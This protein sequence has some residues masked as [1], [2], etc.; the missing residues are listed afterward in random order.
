MLAVERGIIPRIFCKVGSRHYG[1]G[2]IY[3]SSRGDGPLYRR[4]IPDLTIDRHLYYSVCH[5]QRTEATKAMVD[6]LEC[7]RCL[8]A[9]AYGRVWNLIQFNPVVG[10]AEFFPPRSPY[11]N[12]GRLA[13]HRFVARLFQG[14]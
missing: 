4:P 12:G 5:L 2:G 9:P 10:T 13:V 8:H 3:D 7:T 14:L 1:G 11:V 6:V